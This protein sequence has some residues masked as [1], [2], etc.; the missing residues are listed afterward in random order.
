VDLGTGE[1]MGLEA[2]LRWTH[3][4]RGVVPPATFVPVAEESGLILPLGAWVLNEA[5]E[6]GA[7]WNADRGDKPITMTVNISG[8]QLLS[9]MLV[10]EVANVLRRTGLSPQSLILEITETVL[11][12]ETATTLDR[13]T[14]LKGLGVRLA[15][16]DFGTGYSSLSYL[17]QFPVDIIKIDQSFIEGLR[18]GT[19]DTAL[20]RTIIALAGSLAL[21]TIA[22]GVEELQQQEQLR[23]LGCDSAQGF[24]FSR[25]MTGSEIEELMA[26]GVPPE[27]RR[28]EAVA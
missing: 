22:E 27:M 14:Q 5:C 11:M 16:D 28:R 3:P 19:N 15:I 20:V 18:R 17:Q 21:R 24:L 6:H 10:P 7:R 12:H 9:D 8:K 4:K 26:S 2:L 23:E 13:L 1:L 25:P